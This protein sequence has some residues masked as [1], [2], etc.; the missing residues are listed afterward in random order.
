VASSS[1]RRRRRPNGVVLC[2][3]KNHKQNIATAPSHAPAPQWPAHGG[4]WLP[5]KT[6]CPGRYPTWSP[7]AP[8]D[9]TANGSGVQWVS[10]TRHAPPGGRAPTEPLQAFSY[11]RKDHRQH[12]CQH[13]RCQQKQQN[14]SLAFSVSV[15]HAIAPCLLPRGVC[16]PCA[17]ERLCVRGAPLP[18]SCASSLG[19]R[20]PGVG[21]PGGAPQVVR[22]AAHRICQCIGQ[23]GHLAHTGGSCVP[24][25]QEATPTTPLG[26]QQAAAIQS[27]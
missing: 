25:Q 24:S 14:H 22:C 27:S 15:R 1:R 6:S 26:V 4:T 18:R 3:C 21:S 16:P 9:D 13:E 7:R 5:L 19:S 8:A 11:R 17:L 12:G 20:M 23:C 10:R 2:A